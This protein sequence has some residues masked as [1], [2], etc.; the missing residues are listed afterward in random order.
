MKIDS[1]NVTTLIELSECNFTDAYIAFN[2]EYL[3]CL[4]HSHRLWVISLIKS[5]EKL[6]YDLNDF[7]EFDEIFLSV[8]SQGIIFYIQNDQNDFTMKSFYKTSDVR[9]LLT[10]EPYS[11]EKLSLIID[12]DKLSSF[13]SLEYSAI[14]FYNSY[15]NKIFI[16]VNWTNKQ[17]F[18]IFEIETEDKITSIYPEYKVSFD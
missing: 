17:I 12:A 14:L 7:L 15:E 10:K 4:D 8:T 1:K 3:L 6:V 5:T 11:Q 16:C 13:S 2:N 9:D 18:N